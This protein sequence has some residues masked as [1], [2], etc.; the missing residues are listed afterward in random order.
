M[1]QGTGDPFGMPPP[2]TERTIVQVRGDH[3]LRTDLATVQDA[4]RGWLRGLVG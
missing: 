3:G 4:I 1:V 2:G